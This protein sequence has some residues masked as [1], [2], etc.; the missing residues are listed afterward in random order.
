MSKK[1]EIGKMGETVACTCLIKCGYRILHTNWRFGRYE[2][3]IVATNG[4][5]LVV[6]EV[7]TRAADYLVAPEESVNMAKIRRI[8]AAADAYVQKY[9]LMWPVRFDVIFLTADE[10]TCVVD[11]HIKDAFFAPVE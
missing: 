5:E 10:L 1:G 9:D 11:E 2:L 4:E 6:I 8:V 7:K 3:D